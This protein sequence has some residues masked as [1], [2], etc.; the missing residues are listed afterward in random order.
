MSYLENTHKDN[1]LSVALSPGD[2]LLL[3]RV[4][5]DKYNTISTTVHPVMVRLVKQKEEI[6]H[7]R[8]EIVSYICQREVVAKAFTRWLCYF[9]DHREEFYVSLNPKKSAES[10][11]KAEIATQI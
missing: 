8:K 2:G 3:E 11:D 4:A 5:Y 6:D 9:D 10:G 1:V 7:F